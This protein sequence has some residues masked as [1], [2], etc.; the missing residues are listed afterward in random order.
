MHGFP[1][2]AQTSVSSDLTAAIFLLSVGSIISP[3]PLE[4][5]VFNEVIF[6]EASVVRRV[7]NM[8]SSSGLAFTFG[9]AVP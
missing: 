8:P 5:D 9:V 2:D 4:I 1:Y 7:F 3:K 6:P